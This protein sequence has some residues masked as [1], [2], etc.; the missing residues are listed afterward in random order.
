[1]SEP[2]ETHHLFRPSPT[3]EKAFRRDERLYRLTNPV[4]IVLL[5]VATLAIIIGWATFTARDIDLNDRF[6]F[7]D[8]HVMQLLYVV[9]LLTGLWL[10]I[11]WLMIRELE[12]RVIFEL[13]FLG[14]VLL[15]PSFFQE[16]IVQG[17]EDVSVRAITRSCDEG[18]TTLD[19]CVG[20]PVS[21]ENILLLGSD[22]REHPDVAPRT[23]T[24]NDSS[25][26]AWQDLPRGNYMVYVMVAQ[27]DMATC[28]TD[29]LI[30]TASG[31]DSAECLEWDGRIWMMIPVAVREG[32][33]T[34]QIA[35]PESTLPLSSSFIGF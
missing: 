13:I 10:L 12:A 5:L 9:A 20:Y 26:T 3:A 25:I 6:M 35:L 21:T 15:I 19:D 4:L 24:Y 11:R 27:R 32:S 2:R 8:I 30:T 31:R 33:Q 7:R 16:I 28:S 18:A 34:I 22:P 1:M 17:W 23:A 29:G 14:L